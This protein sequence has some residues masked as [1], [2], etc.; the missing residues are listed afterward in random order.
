M[1]LFDAPGVRAIRRISRFFPH[2]IF[3]GI[4]PIHPFYPN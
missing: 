2:A 3:S 1:F 4:D